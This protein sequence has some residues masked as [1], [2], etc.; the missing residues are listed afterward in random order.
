MRDTRAMNNSFKSWNKG[1]TKETSKSLA[2]VSY[3]V[4]KYR[5]GK[6][7]WNKGLARTETEKKLQSEKMK[8]CIPWN[9]GL[10]KETDERV[11][12]IANKLQGHKS[13]VTDWRLA[14]SRE[15]AT[16]KLHDSFN[17]S[18]YEESYYKYLLTKYDSDDIVRQY[19]DERY[20]FNCDF[21]IKSEDLFIELNYHWTH[22][23]H[24]FNA[25]CEH[26]LEILRTIREKQKIDENGKKNMYFYFEYIWTVRDVLKYKTLLENNLNFIIIYPNKIVYTNYK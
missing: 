22:G 23:G 9:K 21:Y 1:L 26:D 12:K 15:Y 13:F 6:S 8:G 14:K 3:K 24:A 10:T 7:S 5:Q 18:K 2:T 25:N 17:T 19:S 16:K 11:A 4:S 20:P